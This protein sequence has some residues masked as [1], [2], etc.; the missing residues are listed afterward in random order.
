MS[1]ATDAH[2][3]ALDAP[4]A[5]TILG[6]GIRHLSAYEVRPGLMKTARKYFPMLI[7]VRSVRIHPSCGSYTRRNAP[8]ASRTSTTGKRPS[9]AR[10]PAGPSTLS[11]APR[12]RTP[13][14]RTGATR[15]SRP[16][17]PPPFP[18]PLHSLLESNFVSL[19]SD[20]A[21]PPSDNYQGRL[22]HRALELP[23]L[24]RGRLPRH[25]R[26]QGARRPRGPARVPERGG[27]GDV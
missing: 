7:F 22:L 11:S 24:H 21:R 10:A 17:P 2:A 5:R 4:L 25:R 13:P 15:T 12:S 23:R 3:H 8:S 9:P 14:A 6:E 18:P 16:L 26:R 1:P 19:T 20:T 27:R